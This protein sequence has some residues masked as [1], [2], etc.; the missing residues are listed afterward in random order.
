VTVFA[1]AK[2]GQPF[3]ANTLHNLVV[4]PMIEESDVIVL[5]EQVEE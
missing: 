1:G 2:P 4:E 5:E 3:S